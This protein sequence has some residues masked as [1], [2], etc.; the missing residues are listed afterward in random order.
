MTVRLFDRNLQLVTQAMSLTQR[1]QALL[2]SNLANMDT[3]G[4]RA[5]DL[6]FEDALMQ[7]YHS[8]QRGPLKT[9][10]ARHFD[11]IEEEPLPLVQGREINSFNPDPRMDGNTV[12]L[13]TEMAKQAENQ[14]LLQAQ[15]RA[16]NY[17]FRTIKAAITE[18]GR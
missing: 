18:G 14:L 15:V 12:N 16:V 2:N 6:V 8:D 13:D 17:K 11:G 3:P 9:A 4:Y 10:D 5:Q 1:R 7:A